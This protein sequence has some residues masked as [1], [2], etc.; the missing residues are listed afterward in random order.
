MALE[1]KRYGATMYIAEYVTV[2]ERKE[3]SV[4]GQRV[5]LMMKSL[6][7][8]VGEDAGQ[9]GARRAARR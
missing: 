8:E 2:G 3:S 9:V 1:E 7:V 6:Q 5:L 4:E